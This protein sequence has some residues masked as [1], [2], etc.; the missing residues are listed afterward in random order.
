MSSEP[1]KW[2]QTFGVGINFIDEDHKRLIG[3]LEK[4]NRVGDPQLLDKILAELIDYTQTHFEREEL[5]M[6]TC[7]YPG[8][9]AHQ[10]EHLSL[11]EQVLK[12]QQQLALGQL[13]RSKLIVFLT[14]WLVHHIGTSDRAMAQH[15]LQQSDRVD[16]IAVQLSSEYL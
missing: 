15:C 2:N 5:L 9:E 1:V 6:A 12:L 13:P 3:L 8:F 16:D 11:I 10:Q 14:Q 7:T 4:C